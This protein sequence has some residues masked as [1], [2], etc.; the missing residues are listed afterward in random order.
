MEQGLTESQEIVFNPLLTAG[1]DGEDFN[2][3]REEEEEEEKKDGEEFAVARFGGRKSDEGAEPE[4]LFRGV[5]LSGDR[6]VASLSKSAVVVSKPLATDGAAYA[7]NQFWRKP[8]YL[9]KSVCID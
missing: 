5:D 8:D 4:S 9:V 1:K 6:D 7:D 2:D 3:R